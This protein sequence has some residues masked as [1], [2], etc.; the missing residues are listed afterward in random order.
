MSKVLERIRTYNK[1]IKGLEEI[2]NSIIE[3]GAGK[4]ALFGVESKLFEHKGR[5]E[6]ILDC[7]KILDVQQYHEVQ[8]ELLKDL[9]REAQDNNEG[10]KRK[11]K[12][13]S[14]ILGRV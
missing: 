4:E 7:L 6:G 5:I 13:L 9:K 1:Y 8:A 2:R 14:R 11:S 12:T 10:G 3:H